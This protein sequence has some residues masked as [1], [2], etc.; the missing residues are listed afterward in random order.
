MNSSTNFN[1]VDFNVRSQCQAVAN[2]LKTAAR[3]RNLLSQIDILHVIQLQAECAL[4]SCLC[5]RVYG[6]NINVL[7]FSLFKRSWYEFEYLYL[8]T[9]CVVELPTLLYTAWW[10]AQL[11]LWSTFNIYILVCTRRNHWY[12]TD[13]NLVFFIFLLSLRCRLYEHK[14]YQIPN[15]LYPV[16]GKSN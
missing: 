3:L 15:L 14:S 16:L 5:V 12:I 4:A 7:L 10:E 13:I 11:C 9:R 1:Q 6:E 2:T 8:D